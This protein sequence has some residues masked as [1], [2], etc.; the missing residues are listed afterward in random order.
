[1]LALFFG[2][3]SSYPSSPSK[4][5]VFVCYLHPVP[6]TTLL[7]TSIFRCKQRAASSMKRRNN[8]E[9][10]GSNPRGTRTEEKRTFRLSCSFPSL[11][12]WLASVDRKDTGDGVEKTTIQKRITRK[13][14]VLY[15]H[16]LFTFGKDLVS[17]Y[18]KIENN[19]GIALLPDCVALALVVNCGSNIRD[20]QLA[21][22]INR[23]VS[24]LR[25]PIHS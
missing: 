15:H 18:R 20:S 11:Y 3:S 12:P 5:L 2:T 4:Y 6:D 23:N 24:H 17:N 13:G 8:R 1:M 16:L 21:S 25:R 10:L 7:Q 19:R 14:N 9:L 22:R